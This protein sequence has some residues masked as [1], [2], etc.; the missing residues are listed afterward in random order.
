M[1]EPSKAQKAKKDVKNTGGNTSP[2]SEKSR[3]KPAIPSVYTSTQRLQM[4]SEAA[5]YIAEKRGFTDGDPMEDW[6]KAENLIDKQLS[7]LA[8]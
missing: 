3:K 5:Y 4:I 6:L 2:R 7:Q 1:L 8:G